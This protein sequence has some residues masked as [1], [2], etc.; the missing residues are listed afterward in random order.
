MTTI[1]ANPTD[2]ETLSGTRRMF[3]RWLINPALNYWVPRF[4]VRPFLK[5]CESDV[6]KESFAHP[7]SWKVMRLCYE[8]AAGRGWVDRMAVNGSAMAMGLR[9][10]KKMVKGNLLRIFEERKGESITIVGVGS[11]PAIC[12]IEAIAASPWT[13]VKAVCVDHDDSAFGY[14]EELKEKYGLKE[15]VTFL[16]GDAVEEMSRMKEE[17]DVIEGVGLIEYLQDR[18]LALLFDFAY[19][20]LKP[21]GVLL[22][23]SIQ[24]SHGVHHFLQRIFGLN[25][26][27]RSEETLMRFMQKSGFLSFRV[28]REPLGIYSLVMAE[29]QATKA[30]NLTA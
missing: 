10:R 14:G 9:N 7:G 5:W 13:Q 6:I 2:F 25:L 12:M 30:G 19:K 18:D 3:K 21:G 22:V 27:Y 15:R 11:G 4:I 17:P 29:K 20:S 28:E 23:N 8:N 16:K 24:P 1:T 26:I